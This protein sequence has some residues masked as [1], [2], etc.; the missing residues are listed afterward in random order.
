MPITQDRMLAVLGEAQLAQEAHN[1]L[2]EAARDLLERNDLGPTA[3]LECLGLLFA[4]RAPLTLLACALEHQHFSRA[5]H[6]NER[7]KAKMAKR[8]AERHG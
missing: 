3:K 4:Q 2:L 5:Q 1:Q 6:A 7:N 8:R